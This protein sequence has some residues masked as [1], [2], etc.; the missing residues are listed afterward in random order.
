LYRRGKGKLPQKDVHEQAVV[1][2]RVAYLKQPL[3][4]YPYKNFQIYIKKWKRYVAVL[5][6]QISEELQ[7]T[8]FIK[9]FFCFFKPIY[10]FC[11]IY[12]RHKGFVDLWPGFVFA[13]FSALRFPV[14][15][16][17]YLTQNSKKV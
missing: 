9:N 3:L 16:F 12:I 14:A 17:Q 5:S 13:L 6:V 2:G 10:W 11:L 7:H 1:E 15:Y 8:S 4:H